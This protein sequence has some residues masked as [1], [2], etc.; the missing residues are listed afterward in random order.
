MALKP[1]WTDFAGSLLGYIRLGLT[2]V[3][4]KNSGGALAVRNAG[5]SADAAVTASTYNGITITAQGT[6]FAIAGGGVS[7]TLTVNGDATVPGVD[8]TEL[9][10]VM[11]G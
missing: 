11:G 5:D 7:K 8:P 10:I 2:G 6:G 4:L 9:A 1:Y 3:R